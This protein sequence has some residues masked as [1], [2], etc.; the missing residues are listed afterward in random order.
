M[1]KRTNIKDIASASGVSITT[2]SL[3]FN[4]KATNIPQETIDRVKQIAKEKGYQPN[5]IAMS[6]KTK[7]TK[8]IG[9]V[10]PSIE[11]TFFAEIA[12]KVEEY[13]D[14]YGYSLMICSSNDKFE[15]DYSSINALASRMIDFLIYC[16]SAETLMTKENLKKINNLLDNLNIPYVVIDRQIEGNIQNKIVCDDH[17]GAMTATQ[18]MIDK[19]HRK[20]ACIAGPLETSSAQNRYS[21]YLDCLKEN[22]ISFDKRLVRFGN[23]DFE[24]GY[25]SMLEII[26][27]NPTAVFA[28]NDLMAYGAIKAIKE[29][30]KTIP[31]DI[32][33]V[34]YDDLIYSQLLDVPLTTIH[35]DMDGIAKAIDEL[36]INVLEKGNVEHTNKVVSSYLVERKSVCRKEK[37]HEKER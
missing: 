21:G 24:S 22:G 12:K 23:F 3:I 4:N 1:N 15:K 26:E 18:Y 31:E 17:Q 30:G 36:I 16:P 5:A 37:G 8:T 34:G 33:I 7:R 28:C 6:L 19:N 29:K 25:R 20:I 9:Y 35:Q 11:N 13:L 10:M 2:V 14:G 32:S 27:E